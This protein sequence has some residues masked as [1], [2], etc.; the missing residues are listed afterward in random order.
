MCSPPFSS[1]LQLTLFL[2]QTMQKHSSLEEISGR[3]QTRVSSWQGLH[4]LISEEA[5]AGQLTGLAV[6]AANLKNTRLV[7]LSAC[8]SSAGQVISGESPITLAH[9]F[10]AAGAQTVIA[11]LWPVSDMASSR[12]SS[13]FY[14]SLCERG[15][16]PS[17][18]LTAAKVSMQ[19]DPQFSH[20]Q[21]WA[22]YV[23]I[24][25]DFPLFI[26]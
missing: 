22:P 14:T 5:G 9:A 1:T 11:T 13:L 17:E 23:C 20:W 12:F 3:A 15:V 26:K 18:A 10:R 24:G 19:Q 16:R 6:C 8:S 21:H 25:C 7:Y 4:N 2:S